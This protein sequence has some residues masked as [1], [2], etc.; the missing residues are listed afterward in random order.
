MTFCYEDMSLYVPV[1]QRNDFVSARKNMHYL[2]LDNNV[3]N[4][5]FITKNFV[6]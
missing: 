2:N 6:F 4:F 3:Y 5:K 1:L